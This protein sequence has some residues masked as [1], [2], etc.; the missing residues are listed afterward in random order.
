LKAYNQQLFN[1]LSTKGNIRESSTANIFKSIGNI[2][3]NTDLGTLTYS[4]QKILTEF[5]KVGP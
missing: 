5:S 2:M 4:I 3:A 1:V